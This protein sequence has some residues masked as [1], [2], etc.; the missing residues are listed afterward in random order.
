M[1]ARQGKRVSSN[2]GR[3]RCGTN[4]F[5][6]FCAVSN[7]PLFS[8]FFECVMNKSFKFYCLKNTNLSQSSEKARILSVPEIAGNE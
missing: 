6:Y 1:N 7:F 2:P 5:L 4:N 8:H 3:A